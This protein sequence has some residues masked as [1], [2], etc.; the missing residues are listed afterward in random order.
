M[1]TSL[2]LS[3]AVMVLSTG[4]AKN[5]QG[6]T[7]ALYFFTPYNYSPEYL[8]GQ[9]KSVK[10]VN[11]W[12]VEK[13]GKYTEGDT[14]SA[15]ERDSLRWSYDFTAFFDKA[16]LLTR[17]DYWSANTVPNSWVVENEANLPVKATWLVA[18]TPKVYFK[19]IYDER[20]YLKENRR[21]RFGDDSLLNKFSLVTN[22]KGQIVEA[23][24]FDNK[25][26]CLSKSMFFWNDSSRVVAYYAYSPSDS[27]RSGF[28]L[29]YG[30]RGFY[31]QQALFRGDKKAYRT[32]R[33]QYLDYDKHGN[34]LWALI[35]DNGKASF[36]VKRIYEYY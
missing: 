22:E 30:L 31:T 25:D 9:V 11:Y 28:T 2:F 23:R 21:F 14:I 15:R 13:N 35:Y 19:L 29:E 10:E 33:S 26:S 36:M 27:L 4:C 5:D 24:A 12:A 7:T 6:K 34:W 1:R 32:I 16:G 17:I 3:L 8:N 18:D 20:G